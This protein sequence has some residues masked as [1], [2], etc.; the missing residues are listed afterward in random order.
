MAQAPA[1]ALRTTFT[2]LLG[3]LKD[4]ALNEHQLESWVPH[5]SGHANKLE[6]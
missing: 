1:V 4:N 3:L 6:T 5:G 2:A